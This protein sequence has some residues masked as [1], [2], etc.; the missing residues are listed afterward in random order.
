MPSHAFN[1]TSTGG[2]LR[3]RRHGR[4]TFLVR[5]LHERPMPEIDPSASA[6]AMALIG[7]WRL[8]S[9]RQRLVDGSERPSPLYGPNGIGYLVYSASGHMCA[10]L[11]SPERPKWVDAGNPTET[12]L[13][14]THAHFAAYCGR[15]EVNEAE[16]LLIHQIE[17]H[18]NPNLCGDVAVRRVR[19]DGARLEL[20]PLEDELPE[21][22]VEYVLTWLRCEQS[23]AVGALGEDA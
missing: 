8:E 23:T 18:V 13:R 22:V 21:G 5:R 10:I 14:S 19:L 6:L 2:V 9:T 1:R 3:R 12:E 17:L 15:F 11:A 7:A 20:R 4:L 16:G